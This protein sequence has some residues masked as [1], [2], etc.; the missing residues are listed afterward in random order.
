M[1]G[2][3]GPRGMV[4]P[5]VGGP[6]GGSARLGPSP[7]RLPGGARSAG[8]FPYGRT[9]AR[10]DPSIRRERQLARPGARDDKNFLTRRAPD[11]VLRRTFIL[12][13]KEVIRVIR[14]ALLLLAVFAVAFVASAIHSKADAANCYYKCIC[15]RSNKCCIVNGVETCKPAAGIL[16]PQ[17]YPC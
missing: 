2:R 11:V 15:G 3:R 1:G 14:K 17:S 9:E 5:A 10:S 16:C 13:R 8:A 12:S 4:P 6:S 7:A